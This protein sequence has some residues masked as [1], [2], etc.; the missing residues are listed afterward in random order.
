MSDQPMPTLD[1]IMSNQSPTVNSPPQGQPPVSNPPPVQP[2]PSNPPPQQPPVNPLGDQHL[3]S[4]NSML[5]P[6]YNPQQQPPTNNPPKT[7][8]TTLGATLGATGGATILGN[9]GTITE[10]G[11]T[12]NKAETNNWLAL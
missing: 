10:T 3:P 8:P 7:I 12:D 5:S 9:Q 11:D 4:L 1:Q 2:P 6:N